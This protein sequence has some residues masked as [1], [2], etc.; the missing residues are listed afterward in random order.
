MQ[1]RELVELAAVIAANGPQLIASSAP[2]SSTALRQY[3]TASKSRLDRWYRSLK[4][5]TATPGQHWTQLRPVL[6]EIL[7]GEVLTRVWTAVVCSHERQGGAR[8]AEPLMRS[9]LIGHLEARNRVLSL[10][11][12]SSAVSLQAAVALNQ[13]RRRAER[14]T[15][16]LLGYLGPDCDVGEWAFDSVRAQDFADDWAGETRSASRR[17]AWKL[18]M[19]SLRAG[20]LDPTAKP[21]PNADLNTQIA[22]SILASLDPQLFD[23]TGPMRSLWITRLSIVTSDTQGLLSELLSLDDRRPESRGISIVPG[24][25]RRRRL[26]GV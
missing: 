26:P 19:A 8:D 14:W 22:T 23:S 18:L 25:D 16:L 3:W 5:H 15:D 2:V 13:L 12:D 7:T 24:A 4:E 11:V 1:A 21:S 17:Q 9:V 20:F 6:D 10:I